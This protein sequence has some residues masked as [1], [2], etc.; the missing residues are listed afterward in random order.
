MLLVLAL[1]GA[2]IGLYGLTLVEWWVVPAVSAVVAAVSAVWMWRR[3]LALAGGEKVLAWGAHI[4][5]TTGLLMALLYGINYFGAADA[6]DHEVRVE[7]ERKYSRTH[8]D[9]TRHGRRSYSSSGPR[10]SYHMDVRFPDGRVK[11]MSLTLSRY[12]RVR[13]GDRLTLHVVPGALGW[14]VMKGEPVFDV[15]P[16]PRPRR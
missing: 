1:Y 16:R 2:G 10:R 9:T 7:V 13:R 14:G 6:A 5:F 3:W 12:N 8:R 4:V 11:E 15:R